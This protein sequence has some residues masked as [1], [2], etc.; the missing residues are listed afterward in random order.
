MALRAISFTI[1]VLGLR[2]RGTRFGPLPVA[3]M[4]PLHDHTIR[5]GG[6]GRANRRRGGRFGRR[7]YNR[8]IVVTHM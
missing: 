7:R 5:I 8:E 6:E 1:G 2:N 3:S 4:I